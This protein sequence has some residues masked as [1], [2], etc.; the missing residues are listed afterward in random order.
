MQSC[1]E[2]IEGGEDGK[3]RSFHFFLDTSKRREKKKQGE[4]AGIDLME[5][6]GIKSR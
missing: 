4:H 5:V 1:E 6:D 3:G 2:G